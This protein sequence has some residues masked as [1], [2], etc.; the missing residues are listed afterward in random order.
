MYLLTWDEE[1][2]VIEASL[3][4]RITALEMQVLGEEMLSIL[5]QLDGPCEVLLDYTKALPFDAQASFTMGEIKDRWLELG[6]ERIVSV[7]QENIE[8][9][10]HITS[11]I[12]QVLD[13]REAFVRETDAWH[14]R[15][16][17]RQVS[18]LAA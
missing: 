9:S 4:G 2:C 6:V 14:G 15:R 5:T 13:G 12:Q 8:I 7:P 10:E 16:L 3:G 11:R 17:E 18:R 1:E